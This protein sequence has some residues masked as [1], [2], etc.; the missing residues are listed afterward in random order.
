M[1]VLKLGIPKGSLEKATIE[2]GLD[3]P[4]YTQYLRYMEGIVNGDLGTSV[5]TRQ[6]IL[7]DIKTFLPATLE[8]VLAGMLI[9]IV[10]G[11][12]LGVLS[13]A[14]KGSWLTT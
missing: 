2:L 5:T 8:L 11:I 13:G 4:L 6:P 3:K 14:N 9:A 12:P 7:T 1:S 10:I